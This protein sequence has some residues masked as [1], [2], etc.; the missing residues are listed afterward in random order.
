MQV[1]FSGYLQLPSSFILQKTW[2]SGSIC[3]RR[4]SIDWKTLL[5]YEEALKDETLNIEALNIETL[6]MGEKEYAHHLSPGR[7]KRHCLAAKI[8]PRFG[9]L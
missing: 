8:Y 1:R 6:N 9:G 2:I 4:V 3:A 5:L 7:R